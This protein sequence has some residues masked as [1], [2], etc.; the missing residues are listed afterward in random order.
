MLNQ[1]INY[2]KE[3]LYKI[4]VTRDMSHQ[5]KSIQK[6][7]LSRSLTLT[8]IEIGFNSS[9]LSVSFVGCIL[10]TKSLL[11]NVDVINMDVV[12]FRISKVSR[13]SYFKCSRKILCRFQIREVGS[14]VSVRTPISVEKLMNSSRLH[15]SGRHGNRSGR[16]LEFEKIPTLLCWHGLGRQLAP[17]RTLGQHRLDAEIFDKEIACIHSSSVR[18]PGQHRPDTV[19]DMTIVCRQDATVWTLGQ[20]RPNVTLRCVSILC[21]LHSGWQKYLM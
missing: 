21:W 1:S 5:Q 13:E 9:I 3:W 15:P 10:L 19:L 14:Y 7:G 6:Y 4:G 12:Y 8:T 20:H 2:T 18:T 17:I 16:F 11:C